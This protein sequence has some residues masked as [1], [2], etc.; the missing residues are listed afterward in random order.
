MSVSLANDSLA[1]LAE[2]GRRRGS[3]SAEDLGRVLP[4]ERMS[5]EEIG[6]TV[7]YLEDHGIEV[8]LDPD[9]LVARP[10]CRPERPIAG[11]AS[12]SPVRTAERS[13]QTPDHLRRDLR[14]QDTH[15]RAPA[16]PR[17]EIVSVV[18]A[19]LIVCAVVAVLVWILG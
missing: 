7:A 19:G 4:I 2:L 6:T 8:T 17:F 10:L 1:R 12:A 16:R 3:L 9:L 5:D 14:H 11:F 18:L 13:S 15:G